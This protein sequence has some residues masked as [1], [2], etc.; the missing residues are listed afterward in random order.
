M[1]NGTATGAETLKN[2]V[3]PGIGSFTVVDGSK[4]EPKDLGN[5]WFVTGDSLGQSRA[6]TVMELLREMNE[7]VEGNYVEEDASLLITS[8]PDFFLS[9]SLVIVTDLPEADVQKLAK[10][11]WQHSIP[12]VIARSYGF[13]GHLRIAVPEHTSTFC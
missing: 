12:L 10:L 6:K 7:E 13:Y 9:F 2:L 4:V 8:N 5:N 3:L 11:L 1:I